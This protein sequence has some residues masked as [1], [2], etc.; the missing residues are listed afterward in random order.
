MV[1][2]TAAIAIAAA[3]AAIAREYHA[4]ADAIGA[5]AFVGRCTGTTR[6]TACRSGSRS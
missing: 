4:D 5:T 2:R 6:S 3:A 1:L